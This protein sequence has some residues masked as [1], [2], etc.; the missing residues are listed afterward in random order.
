MLATLQKLGVVPSFSRPS[1]NDGNPY[2]EAMFKTLK[3][4]PD[5]PAKRFADIDQA[6]AWA[7]RFVSWHNT[8]HR[9][10]G[11]RFVTPEQRHTGL[12]HDILTSRIVVY[13]TAKQADPARW[14]NRPTRNW[15]PGGSVWV[16]PDNL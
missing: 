14:K 10:S 12:E 6:R 3:Y 2:S 13:D 7:Q 8:D 16:N 5:Y 11:I 4:S 9:H 1:V 15:T